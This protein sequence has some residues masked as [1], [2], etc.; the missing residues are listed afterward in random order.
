M[1]IHTTKVDMFLIHILLRREDH[2]LPAVK[3]K[4]TIP[5]YSE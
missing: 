1:Q 3:S 2:R 4:V 5:S